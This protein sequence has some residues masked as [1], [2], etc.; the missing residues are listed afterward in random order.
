MSDIKQQ[1]TSTATHTAET[2][3]HCL[4][5][6]L[7]MH[8]AMSSRHVQEGKCSLWYSSISDML[9]SAKRMRRKDERQWLTS[10]LTIHRDIYVLSKELPKLHKLQYLPIIVTQLCM[11]QYLP[12]IT[13]KLQNA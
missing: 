9:Q 11:M 12:I 6:L 13:T 10:R 5:S 8:S 3:H 7:D 4:H 2:F 1:L